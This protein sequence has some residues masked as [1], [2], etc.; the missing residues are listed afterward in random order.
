VRHLH[1]RLGPFRIGL[2]CIFLKDARNGRHYKSWTLN[3]L[4]IADTD[5]VTLDMAAL[6]CYNT[7]WESH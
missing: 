6:S 2:E 1:L 5:T 4:V 7:I 3:V